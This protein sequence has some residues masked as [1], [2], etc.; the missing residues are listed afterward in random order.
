MKEKNRQIVYLVTEKLIAR[1][2]KLY[3]KTKEQN[4]IHKF[5]LKEFQEHIRNHVFNLPICFAEDTSKVFEDLV[6][7]LG[8]DPQQVYGSCF[9]EVA[10]AVWKQPQ[11]LY[12]GLPITEYQTN[13]HS[14]EK[15]VRRC[16]K[17]AIAMLEITSKEV[18][19]LKEV[20]ESENRRIEPVNDY[21]NE[22]AEEPEEP[23]EE[24]EELSEEPKEPEEEPKE[25]EEEPDDI[26]AEP[27]EPA[28]EPDESAE[29]PDESAEEPDESAE[30]PDEI[31]EEP[32]ESAEEL[33]EIAEE[34]EESAEELDEIAEEQDEPEESAPDPVVVH[35]LSI[36]PKPLKDAFQTKL[37]DISKDADILEMFVSKSD[38]ENSD[39]ETA[40]VAYDHFNEFF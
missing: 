36:R 21:K 22:L 2:S 33:D 8:C 35:K 5:I 34:P 32:E 7:R 4:K 15:L 14:Y 19:V 27:E 31:A 29:E 28:E 18:E 20:N 38:R 11:L 40:V 30:E 16:V 10:R 37:I 1:Y 13:A 9:K 12:H 3:E 23:A 25:P 26:T 6:R 24:P 39:E 17:D